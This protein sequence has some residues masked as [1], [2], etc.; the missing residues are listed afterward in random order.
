MNEIAIN[1]LELERSL[2]PGIALT[3]SGDSC[4]VLKPGGYGS[5][6]TITKLADMIRGS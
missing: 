1:N 4:F 5:L 2:M 6:D 3:R